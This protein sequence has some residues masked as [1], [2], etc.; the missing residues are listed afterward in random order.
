MNKLIKE[1]RKLYLNEKIISSKN[2][3]QLA[4]VFDNAAK[5]L[6]NSND[7]LYIIYS[8]DAEDN[9]SYE[10]ESIEIFA[11]NGLIDNKTIKKINM[12]LISF[13]QS[14]KIEL[15]FT[16]SIENK[17]LEN[18]IWVSGNDTIW[19]NGILKQ[20]EDIV[21]QSEPQIGSKKRSL[22]VIITTFIIGFL[23]LRY[24][25]LFGPYFSRK[26][27]NTLVSLFGV[28]G[29][30]ILFFTL[31]IKSLDFIHE[32][33][34]NIELKTGEEYLQK[35]RKRKILI[36]G[37]ITSIISITASYIFDFIKP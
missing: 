10:S 9:S 17:D 13:K 16:H 4:A 8:L 33:F 25:V 36:L 7:D 20:F 21:N 30:L 27:T 1:K 28:L 22:L 35:A 6:S 5:E 19:V 12:S 26:D 23:C 32:G 14:Y 29:P 11:E 31:F 37:I 18:Y 3:R 15:Q 34:P 2:I 24:F